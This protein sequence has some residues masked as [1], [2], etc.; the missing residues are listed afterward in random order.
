MKILSSIK[1][2]LPL[3]L[4]EVQ[5]AILSNTNLLPRSK[6]RA[7]LLLKH[8]A[9]ASGNINSIN[10]VP[11][12]ELHT[13]IHTMDKVEKALTLQDMTELA[14]DAYNVNTVLLGLVD[15]GRN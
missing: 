8:V 5:A 1:G 10:G 6:H 14:V 9:L 7:D 11:V 3:S 4:P 13:L 2:E 15:K 12:I